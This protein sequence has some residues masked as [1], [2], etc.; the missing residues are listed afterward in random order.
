[1]DSEAFKQWQ[2]EG[3]GNVAADGMFSIQ[4]SSINSSTTHWLDVHTTAFP[5]PLDGS[6]SYVPTTVLQVLSKALEN[7]SLSCTN[8]DSPE[9]KHSKA[10]PEQEQ[11][12][13]CNLE[14]PLQLCLSRSPL[15][16]SRDTTPELDHT[17]FWGQETLLLSGATTSLE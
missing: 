3:S 5:K 16:F 14:V 17:K 1:M 8:L 7:W 13:I 9:A 12:F 4:A 10:H 15:R 6:T 11:A 2:Q